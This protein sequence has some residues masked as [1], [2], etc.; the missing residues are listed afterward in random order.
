MNAANR[1]G[2]EPETYSNW[3]Q[4]TY[5]TT[6]PRPVEQQQLGILKCYY[7]GFLY[8]QE[9]EPISSNS[10]WYEPYLKRSRYKYRREGKDATISLSGNMSVQ[11][12]DSY[13]SIEW[14]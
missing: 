6:T 11:A 10:P 3:L 2:T 13:Y 12:D 1:D 7:N 8:V 4:E 9:W 14:D 5:T